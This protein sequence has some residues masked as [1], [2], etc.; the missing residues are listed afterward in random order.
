MHLAS[1]TLTDDDRLLS[2]RWAAIW[3]RFRWSCSWPFSSGV[4]TGARPP[5][6]LGLLPCRDL[7]LGVVPTQG[8]GCLATSSLARVVGSGARS[9]RAGRDTDPGTLTLLVRVRVQSFLV[10][11]IGERRA[12]CKWRGRGSEQ[13][14]RG[15]GS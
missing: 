10:H 13:R 8:R 12:W 9:D 15:C 2:M 7:L 5:A 14:H 11:S 6:G 4:S 1:A 3:C